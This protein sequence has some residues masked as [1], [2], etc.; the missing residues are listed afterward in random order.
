MLFLLLTIFTQVGGVVYLITL[1]VSPKIK[2]FK[3]S[4]VKTALLFCMMYLGSTFFIVPY[5]APKF[6]REPVK[7]SQNLKAAT[8]LTKILNR[9]YVVPELNIMLKKA[10]T[11]LKETGI[12]ISYLDANFPFI[13]GFPLWPH[14]SHNDGKKIDLSFVYEDEKGITN[15]TKSTTGY[16]VFE[17]PFHNEVNQAKIC[18]S[19]G[20]IFYDLAKY[21]TLGKKNNHLKFSNKGNQLLLAALVKQPKTS[22][23]FIEPH[24]KQRL[25]LSNKKIRFQGCKAARHDDHIHLQIN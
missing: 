11:Q 18:K 24:L 25:K 15:K 19:Q 6:G 1:I 13:N 5:I 16:G 8:Y 23:I 20:N 12:K 3:N 9:N 2:L 7:H 21:L 17:Q 22:K 4:K 14:F 10:A